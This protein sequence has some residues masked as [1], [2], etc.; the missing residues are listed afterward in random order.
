MSPTAATLVSTFFPLHEHTNKELC[1]YYAL[2]SVVAANT[3]KKFGS[4]RCVQMKR[5]AYKRR[6]RT[7]EEGERKNIYIKCM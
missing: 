1:T 7:M 6:K 5:Q 2:P 4:V 3:R